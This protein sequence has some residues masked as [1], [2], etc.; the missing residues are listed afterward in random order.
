MSDEHFTTD[1]PT[2]VAAHEALTFGERVADGCAA[3]IGSWRF[4]ILQT[5]CILLWLLAN[6]GHALGWLPVWDQPPFILLN[7]ML[8]FQAAFTGP[9]LLLAANRQAKKDREMAARDDE[10]IA[11]LLTINRRLMRMQEEQTDAHRSEITMLR[12]LLG[13]AR[14]HGRQEAV[15][16]PAATTPGPPETGEEIVS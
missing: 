4:I 9:V 5:G 3:A 10:E 7:L 1:E 8:S 14:G 2:R 6:T 12:Q 15:L 16:T 11:E 13:K